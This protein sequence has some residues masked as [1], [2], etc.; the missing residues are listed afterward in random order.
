M[1]GYFQHRLQ[2]KNFV[3][4]FLPTK[5]NALGKALKDLSEFIVRY[6]H[7]EGFGILDKKVHIFFGQPRKDERNSN[8]K[9]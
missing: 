2:P 1:L 9:N 5:E 8:Y 6:N 7:Y 4:E 3:V